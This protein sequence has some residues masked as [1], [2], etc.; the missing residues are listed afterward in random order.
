MNASLHSTRLDR[1]QTT[2]GKKQ[3]AL[4]PSEEHLVIFTLED[5][6][7]AIDI[8]DVWEINTMQNITH[9][10]R[11]PHFIEGVINLR[12]EIIPVMDLRKRLGLG[13]RGYD[14]HSRIMVT[15]SSHNR[16]G[17]IVDSVEEVSK[18]PNSLIKP[19]AELGVLIDEEFVRGVAQK[20]ERLIVLLDLQRLLGEDEQQ[21]LDRMEVM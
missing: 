12:G 15:Q 3:T 17:L 9:V 1:Q 19:T 2:L 5:E 10:P 14:R 16:L 7:Y 20:D 6:C 13:T 8:R 11:T 21:T 18:I 4:P